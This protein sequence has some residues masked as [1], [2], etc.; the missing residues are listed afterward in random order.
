MRRRPLLFM[1]AGLIAV[2]VAVPVAA[3]AI[4]RGGGGMPETRVSTL[5]ALGN[6]FT[7]Q[8]RLI[9]DSAPANGLYDLRFIL[10]DA[11]SGGAQVGPTVEKANVIVTNALFTTELDF[12][13][14][15]FDGNARW[16]EIAIRPGDE[17]GTYTVL[18]PRQP[19]TPV[20]Y[21]LFAKAANLALPFSGSASSAV[22]TAL[23]NLTQTGEG[24][25]FKGAAVDGVGADLSGETGLVVVGTTL[26]IDATGAVQVDGAITRDFGTDEFSPAG[27]IAYGTI[28]SDGAVDAATGNVTSAWVEAEDR[29]EIAIDGEAATSTGYV[30]TVT[31]QT[32]VVALWG[33]EDDVFWVQLIPS[34]ED[35]DFPVQAA[36][37]FVVHKP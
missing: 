1:V 26:A 32:K 24:A 29:Y 14:A 25:A 19:I 16:L 10:F 28:G 37:S 17:A 27:P 13:A 9:D 33:A 23:L 21:A 22:D 2:L 3:G 34:E 11:E 18:S 35:A 15:S 36:F 8:G 7:Y 20:P 30:V 31:P 4:N 5:V 6:A 12:G